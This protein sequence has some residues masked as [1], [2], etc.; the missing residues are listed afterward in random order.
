[1]TGT[2]ETPELLGV[3]V[4]QFARGLALVVHHGHSGFARLQA[5]KAQATK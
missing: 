5:G 3:H 2:H 4:Q 1:M